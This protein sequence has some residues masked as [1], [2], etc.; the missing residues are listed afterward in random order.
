M[1]PSAPAELTLTRVVVPAVASATAVLRMI[2]QH[3]AKT[4]S[5]RIGKV[6]VL[7]M[8]GLDSIAIAGQDIRRCY[9][10]VFP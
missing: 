3:I 6:A 9:S 8:R 2:P 1:F 4:R 7:G 5:E 10:L